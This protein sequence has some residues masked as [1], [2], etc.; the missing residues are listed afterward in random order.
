[1]SFENALTMNL[2]SIVLMSFIAIYS[3]KNADIHLL[4]HKIYFCMLITT[5]LLLIFDIL[6]R[7]DGNP[8]T[9]ISSLN[10]IGNF[11]IFFLNLILPSLW[12]LYLHDQIYHDAEKIKK[13]MLFLIVLNTMNMTAVILSLKY[14]WLYYIDPYNVYHRGDYFL[15]PVMAIMAL[16]IYALILILANGN[17]IERKQFFHLILFTS[18]PLI[19]VAL[20]TI[21][22]GIPFVLNSVAFSLFIAF[23]AIQSQNIHTDYLTGVFNRKKLDSYLREK[24]NSTNDNSSFSAVIIDMNNFKAINDTFGHNAGDNALK[25][26]AELLKSSIRANDFI[27]RFGGDEFFIIFDISDEANLEAAIMRIRKCMDDFNLKA[28]MPYKLEFSIGYSVYDRNLR[29]NVKE[30][31][32]VVDDLMYK[33]K[34]AGKETQIYG[35]ASDFVQ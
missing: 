30:F 1:M 25:T 32:K 14:N 24:I 17:K 5:I 26:F 4:Q 7:L 22:Y 20:Q 35:R 31:Q 18:P 2:Y 10:A 21:F 33:D 13:P 34:L 23:L 27:A 3:V 9:M 8:E 6:G 12:I 16:M 28:V 19:S 29:M 15:I 11:V